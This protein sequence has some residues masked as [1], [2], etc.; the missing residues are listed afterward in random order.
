MTQTAPQQ[1]N[2]SDYRP[3]AHLVDHVHLTFRLAPKGTRVISRIRFRANPAGAGGDLWLDGEGLRLIGAAID[4]VALGPGDYVQ[5]DAGVRVAAAALSHDGFTW[6][7]E[8]EIDPEGNTALEGLYL[9]QGMFCTQCEA[10]GFR[11]ITY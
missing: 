3:P 6:E 4:G 10:E 11:K 8:V 9:S 5:S 2:L 1:I 7:A